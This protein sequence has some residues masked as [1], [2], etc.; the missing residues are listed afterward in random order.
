MYHTT[1][2]KI[3]SHGRKNLDAITLSGTGISRIYEGEPHIRLDPQ[4]VVHLD[5]QLYVVW[6]LKASRA[7]LVFEEN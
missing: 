1:Q 3:W 6:R 2:L 4:A 7:K 5:N